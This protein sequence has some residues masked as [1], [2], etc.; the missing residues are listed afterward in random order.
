M[1]VRSCSLSFIDI[2]CVL[3][4]VC[5]SFCLSFCLNFCSVPPCDLPHMTYLHLTY[6]HVTYPKST[7]AIWPTRLDSFE[8]SFDLSFVVLF[9][10]NCDS[11]NLIEDGKLTAS[12][13][14]G[15]NRTVIHL[16]IESYYKLPLSFLNHFLVLLYI[17]II[18]TSKHTIHSEIP[19][20]QT[21]TDRQ[22]DRQADRQTDIQTD[23]QTNR[24]TDIHTDRHTDRQT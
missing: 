21:Q 4:S 7:T 11:R 23:R 6:P 13:I 22:T 16:Q 1:G 24:Q 15:L 2:A 18:S 9:A 17:N 5:L 20:E 19:R 12:W 3:L 8:R 14:A 10:S